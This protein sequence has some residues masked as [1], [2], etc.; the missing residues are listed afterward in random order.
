MKGEKI[1]EWSSRIIWTEAIV[2]FTIT[3]ILGCMTMVWITEARFSYGDSIPIEV[4]TR[5]DIVFSYAIV[6]YLIAIFD[7]IMFF[8]VDFNYKEMKSYSSQLLNRVVG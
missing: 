3:Y 7:S 2:F 1:L 8:I 5:S 6:S 4:K